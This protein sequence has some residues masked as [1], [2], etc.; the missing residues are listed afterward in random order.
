MK[1][2]LGR[3]IFDE[4]TRTWSFPD[5]SGKIMDEARIEMGIG[6]GNKRGRLLL[7]DFFE[8]KN[9]YSPPINQQ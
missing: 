1:T 8:I 7:L 5:G 9:R 2:F 6:T 3:T 4:K